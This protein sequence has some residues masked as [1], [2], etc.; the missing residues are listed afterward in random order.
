MHHSDPESSQPTVLRGVLGLAILCALLLTLGCGNDKKTFVAPTPTPLATTSTQIRIGDAPVDQILTFEVTIA[1]PVV[2]KLASGQQMN[3]SLSNNRLE[4]SHMAGKM[5]PILV[6]S[7]P[8]GTYSGVEI[9]LVDPAVIYAYQKGWNV[10]SFGE[11]RASLVMKDF[12][13]SQTVKIDFNPAV[14]IGASPTVIGIDINLA[15]A[16]VLDP[17]NQSEITGVNFTPEVFTMT[18]RPIA[19]ADKQQHQDGELESVTG[20]VT[21]YTGSSFTLKAGQSGAELTVTTNNTTQF[22]DNLKSAADALN[23]IVEVEG[24]THSD[25]TLVATEVEPVA[26]ANGAALEGIITDA[27]NL[28]GTRD[29][30][31]FQPTAF[32]I[33]AQDAAGAGA[34]TDD[35]GYTFTVHTTYLTDNAFTVDYGKCDWSGLKT[36]V[37]GPLFPF[38]SRH[39]FPGQRIEVRTSSALPDGDFTHFSGTGVELEQ[40]AVTGWIDW[41][42]SSEDGSAWFMLELPFDS[43]VH[44]L[45]GYRWVW[46]YQG[47]ATDVE[48]LNTDT[49]HT[50]GEGSFVRVR[51]LMFLSPQFYQTAAAPNFSVRDSLSMIARRISEQ[52]APKDL[53]PSLL[54]K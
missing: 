29:V 4:L 47:P 37:P 32:Q 30:L 12:P 20:K 50:I 18:Q 22:H 49:E 45:S 6:S 52:A 9:T 31:G 5:E 43:Y 48:L 10:E 21:A 51:G 24:Y 8:Q 23:R 7:L 33:L 44:R 39:L 15:K 38:D 40:Q 17:D 26:G 2:A 25:G 27:G 1:D 53:P 42:R 13:G 36:D 46:V 54:R 19:S 35:V 11:G 41:Y 16:I 3:I 34:K 28:F 14:T